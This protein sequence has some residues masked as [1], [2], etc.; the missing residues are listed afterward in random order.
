MRVIVTGASGFIGKPLITG[1]ANR[2]STLYGL[3]RH[4]PE[5]SKNVVPLHG[6]VTQPGLGL[7]EIPENIDALYHLAAIHKL[8]DDKN[9]NL[10]AT[11]VTGTRNVIQFCEDH[12]IPHL[13]FCSTAYT[14][15]RNPYEKSKAKCEWMVSQSLGIP[16]VTTFKP[17]IVMGTK[18]NPYLGHVS[19]FIS[20]LIKTH[21]RAELIR[22]KVEGTLRLPILEPVFRLKGDPEGRLNLIAIDD[23]VKAMIEIEKPGTF[24][25]TNPHPPT[26]GQLVSWIGEEI[27]VRL[28]ILP[29]VKYTPLEVTFHK[30]AKPFDPYLLGDNFRS[31][32][33]KVIPI[34]REFIRDVVLNTLNP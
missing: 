22:R 11:N 24:W 3:S 30:L 15:G 2:G 27:F 4:P 5:P 20:L 13:F 33:K 26:L 14:Q 23:V 17:S 28:E 29:H 18:D 34:D 7:K 19:Q 31:D 9:G 1:L 21:K 12:N 25:L 16:E 8:G 10:W 32:I 6:D